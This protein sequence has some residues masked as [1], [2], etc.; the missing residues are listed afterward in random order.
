MPKLVKFWDEEYQKIMEYIKKHEIPE[1]LAESKQILALIEKLLDEQK[2]QQ[3][4][5]L[6]TA[7]YP[8]IC[9]KCNK[10][11]NVGD[12]FF[13]IRGTG[14]GLCLD[15]YAKNISLEGKEKMLFHEKMLKNSIKELEK[16]YQELKKEYQELAEMNTRL[17]I[18][19]V[20][21][22]I[23]KD[24]DEKL[25]KRFNFNSPKELIEYLKI[26]LETLKAV[27]NDINEWKMKQKLK[28]VAK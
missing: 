1:T 8:S 20:F 2:P 27:Q 22:Q 14:K 13:W 7:K 10:P 15:C 9:I 4:L 3:E 11:I 5:I 28:V 18:E 12:V 26:N 24:L 23:V 19:N 21:Y 6:I 16:Q 25:M 17:T